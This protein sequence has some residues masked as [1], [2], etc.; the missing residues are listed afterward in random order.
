MITQLLG[1]VIGMCVGYLLGLFVYEQMQLVKEKQRR[2]K[3]REELDRL[4]KDC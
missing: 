1:L 3:I 4:Y 2:R